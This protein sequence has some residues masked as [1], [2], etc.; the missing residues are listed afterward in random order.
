MYSLRMQIQTFGTQQSSTDQNT[1]HIAL[2]FIHIADSCGELIFNVP[3]IL[4]LLT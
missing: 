2:H 3:V 1:F 4:C